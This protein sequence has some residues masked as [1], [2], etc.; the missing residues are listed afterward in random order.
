[1]AEYAYNYTNYD[2]ESFAPKRKP[3]VEPNPGFEPRIVR[4]ARKTLAQKKRESALYRSR[5][6][7]VVAVSL[8]LFSLLSTR[9][10][11]QVALTSKMKTLDEYNT[12]IK[13]AQ[14]ENVALNNRLYEMMSLDTVETKA[15]KDLHMVKEEN[16][17]IR[18]VHV[19]STDNYTNATL[20]NK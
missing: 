5:L 16:S 4:P 7:K 3:E 13:A 1:M 20:Q 18:Y 6:I 14:S 15:V 2:F 8:V 9:I 10:Y 11:M 19:G 12:K 17:Q